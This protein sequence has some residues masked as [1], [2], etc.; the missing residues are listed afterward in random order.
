MRRIALGAVLVASALA[1]CGE[2]PE[3]E[4]N[5]RDPEIRPL[6]AVLEFVEDGGVYHNVG[7]T[8]Q[9]RVAQIHALQERLG[10]SRPAM[11][12]LESLGYGLTNEVWGELDV[13]EGQIRVSLD[14]PE[15]IGSDSFLVYA[16]LAYIWACPIGDIEAF[17]YHVVCNADECSVVDR[18]A[19]EQA[20]VGF[21]RVACG[22]PS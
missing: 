16:E 7:D 22:G 9:I 3:S 11:L 19:L 12:E 6:T 17:N 18:E 5:D 14:P 21:G 1:G 4:S 2:A 20:E 10:I 13:L 15:P 8:I